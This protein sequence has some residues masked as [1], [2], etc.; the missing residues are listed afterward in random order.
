MK[1]EFVK[2]NPSHNWS[3]VSVLWLHRAVKREVVQKV[4]IT[5]SLNQFQYGK[6]FFLSPHLIESCKD[7]QE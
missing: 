7:I 6:Q 4:N 1:S 3:E 2:P 5:K